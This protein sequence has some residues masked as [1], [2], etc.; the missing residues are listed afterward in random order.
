MGIGVDGHV[1]LFD[2]GFT[3]RMTEECEKCN[4]EQ[5]LAFALYQVIEHLPLTLRNDSVYY[6]VIYLIRQ[7][8][9]KF[10]QNIRA[11]HSYSMHASEEASSARRTRKRTRRTRG[12]TRKR[13][14][15]TKR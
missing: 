6:D 11:F 1:K 7:G 15:K 12:G 8:K 2:Y 9:Y 10:G 14:Y 5:L 3:H 4:R 13:R